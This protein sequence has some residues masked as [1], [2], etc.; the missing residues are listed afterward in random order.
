MPYTLDFILERQCS[1]PTD[2]PTDPRCILQQNITV[3]LF[4]NFCMHLFSFFCSF[5]ILDVCSRIAYIVQ[6]GRITKVS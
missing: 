4:W 3:V 6:R 1:V 2:I 5:S